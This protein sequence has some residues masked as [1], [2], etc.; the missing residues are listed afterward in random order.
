MVKAKLTIQFVD[1]SPCGLKCGNN[2][3]PLAVTP[4]DD[5]GFCRKSVLNI[6]NTT[7]MS[8]PFERICRNF[9]LLYSK[10]AFVQRYIYEGLEE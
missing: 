9:D 1:W 2:Y 10:K 3:E 4:D 5:I 7:A 6:S 8:E